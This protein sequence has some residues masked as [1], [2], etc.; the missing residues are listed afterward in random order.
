MVTGRW[1]CKGVTLAQAGTQCS[2]S[3]AQELNLSEIA[4]LHKVRDCSQIM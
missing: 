4:T 3:A 2:Q 1:S